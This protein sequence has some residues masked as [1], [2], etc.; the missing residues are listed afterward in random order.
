MK[1]VAI[2]VLGLILI[3]LGIRIYSFWVQEHQ[4]DAQLSDVQS[5]LQKEQA[6]AAEMQSDAQYLANPANLEKELK[7]RFNY[8]KP[9]ETMMI[10]VGTSTTSTGN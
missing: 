4:L 2:V 9:G 8:K 7:A 6:S 10:I 5:R 1:I 3:F